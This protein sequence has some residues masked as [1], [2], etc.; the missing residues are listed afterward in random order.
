MPSKRQRRVAE[1]IREVLTEIIQFE[2]SDP[3]LTGV[4]VMEVIVDREFQYATIYVTALDG[5]DAQ[6]DVM[7]GLVSASGFLRRELGSRIRLI[8]TPE[9][10]FEWD[11]TFEEA[12]RI[13]ELL[14][15][16][17]E[18]EDDDSSDASEQD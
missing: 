14:D 9:L 12:L 16:L 7:D 8:N 13:E 11:D 17:K 6:E 4:T 2:A 5:D 10:R 15:N 3:R 18:S 1:Q